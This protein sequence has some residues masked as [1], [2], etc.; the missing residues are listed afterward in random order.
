MKAWGSRAWMTCRN[1]WPSMAWRRQ[2]RG[3]LALAAICA[4]PLCVFALLD[5]SP[6]ND[7]DAY[8]TAHVPVDVL[9]VKL[10][11]TTL[12]RRAHMVANYLV[13]EGGNG[14]PNLCT[15]PL[16]LTMAAFEPSLSLFRLAALPFV[17]CSLL[18]MYLCGRELR[19]HRFGL[20][21]MFV[22]GT[23]PAFLNYSRKWDLM[24]HGTALALPALYLALRI[25][26]RP[27]QGRHGPWLALGTV[28]GLTI[29]AHPITFGHSLILLVSVGA[30]T[31]ALAW[32]TGDARQ[33]ARHC[34]PAAAPVGL[35]ACLPLLAVQE[36]EVARF[37]ILDY[38]QSRMGWF[39]QAQGGEWVAERM[40]PWSAIVDL[41]ET[42]WQMHWMPAATLLLVLP[43]L[44]A[45][46]LAL[47]IRGGRHSRRVLL[48]GVLVLCL[49][50]PPLVW[51]HSHLGTAVDWFNLLPITLLVCLLALERIWRHSWGRPAVLC[52][53][54]ATAWIAAG[55]YHALAPM[56]TSLLSS[57]PLR[58]AGS[59]PML[60][61]FRLAESG[62]A[63]HAHHLIRRQTNVAQRVVDRFR[64]GDVDV[65]PDARAVLGLWDLWRTAQGTPEGADGASA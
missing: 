27:W 45:V 14:L 5:Q 1:L 6:P 42:L 63:N 51:T 23:M 24:V 64:A 59:T 37:S 54:A 26:R 11:N 29:L 2:A 60:A 36:D 4:A 33:W 13:G 10:Y 46:P 56:A 25:L 65:H 34:L 57:D 8:Y 38:T 31:L 30:F 44:L 62:N 18:F 40:D 22:L 20:L 19:G 12:P 58:T 7:H 41:A 53:L 9:H 35:V 17:V 48:F 15:T 50:M 32:R 52:R 21:A 61:G 47:R 28:V 43:G 3:V 39:N 49:H 16:Y 55:A